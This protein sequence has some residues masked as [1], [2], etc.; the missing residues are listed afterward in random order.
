MIDF[1]VIHSGKIMPFEVK[2]RK[3][4]D[5][6]ELA[7]LKTFPKAVV[8][9]QSELKLMDNILLVPASL[10]CLSLRK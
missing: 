1:V 7:Y 6:A 5:T 4:I 9:T 8:V 10:F 2:F 3:G